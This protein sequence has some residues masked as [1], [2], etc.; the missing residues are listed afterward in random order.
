MNNYKFSIESRGFNLS[1][2]ISCS[3]HYTY[4]GFVFYPYFLHI[5]TVPQQLN[6]E[7]LP[8]RQ[9]PAPIQGMQIE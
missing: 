7:T 2:L 1:V 4:G 3:Y 6:T 8:D 5:A 9:F